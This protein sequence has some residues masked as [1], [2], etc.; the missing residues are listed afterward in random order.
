MRAV[1]RRPA[2]AT[3]RENIAIT[4]ARMAP[5]VKFT[6]DSHSVAKHVWRGHHKN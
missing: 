4:P 3:I 1:I 5:R 2:I 6:Q